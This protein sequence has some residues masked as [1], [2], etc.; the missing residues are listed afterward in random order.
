MNITCIVFAQNII[1][2]S[3]LWSKYYFYLKLDP[4]RLYI[5]GLNISVSSTN[6]SSGILVKIQTDI[7]TTRV[8]LPVVLLP[9]YHFSSILNL[10]L[11]SPNLFLQICGDLINNFAILILLL[12]KQCYNLRE[13]CGWFFKDKK[14]FGFKCISAIFVPR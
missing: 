5:A 7:S 2:K 6:Y 1:M 13:I 12:L 8:F 10:F 4:K 11:Q 14:S 9:V 3:F